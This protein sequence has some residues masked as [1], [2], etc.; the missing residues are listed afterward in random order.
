MLSFR[1]EMAGGGLWEGPSLAGDPQT[2]SKGAQGRGQA[3]T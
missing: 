2:L 3:G 1:W